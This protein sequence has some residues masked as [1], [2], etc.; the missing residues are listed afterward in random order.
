MPTIIVIADGADGTKGWKKT[1]SN[2][3]AKSNIWNTPKGLIVR[4]EEVSKRNLE[5]DIASLEKVS[6]YK[7]NIQNSQRR[8]G[9]GKEEVSKW[10]L[11]L[12]DTS[13]RRFF[14]WS[15]A[16]PSRRYFQGHSPRENPISH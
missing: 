5:G 14:H 6:H 1:R 13:I 7:N 2:F 9:Y 16:P 4:T 10:N 11:G 12:G 8:F 15:I 3:V